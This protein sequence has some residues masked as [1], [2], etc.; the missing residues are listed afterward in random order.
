MANLRRVTATGN[1]VTGPVV[2][3]SV[4]LTPAA[5]VSTLELRDGSGGAIVLTLQAAASGSSSV[6]SAGK[7]GVLFSSALHATLSGAG[8]AASFECS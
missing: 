1:V 7:A 8:A 2:L 5:A 6:W 4:M 3:R